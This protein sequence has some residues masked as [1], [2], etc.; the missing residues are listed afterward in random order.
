MNNM[1]TGDIAMMMVRSILAYMVVKYNL[2]TR[3]KTNNTLPSNDALIILRIAL[4]HQK[5]DT[6]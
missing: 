4:Y 3:I 2:T 6:K 5:R 1:G